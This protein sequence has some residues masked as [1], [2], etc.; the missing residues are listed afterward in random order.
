VE[1][2]FGK[3]KHG[4]FLALVL[5]SL[6]ISS[7]ELCY[8]TNLFEDE[9]IEKARVLSTSPTSRSYAGVFPY[10]KNARGTFFLLSRELWGGDKGTCCDFGG[11]VDLDPKT[12]TYFH[13]GSGALNELKEESCLVYDLGNKRGFQLLRD[14]ALIYHTPTAMMA[15][16]ELPYHPSATFNAARSNLIQKKAKH[17]FL[18]KD[19]FIWVEGGSLLAAVE[20]FPLTRGHKDVP[21]QVLNDNNQILNET[22]KLRSS[23]TTSLRKSKNLLR[24]IVEAPLIITPAQPV[25][26]KP[27]E[28]KPVVQPQPKPVQ[29]VQKPVEQP[30]SVQAQPKPVQPVQKPVEQPKPVQA[31]PKPVQPVQKPVEQPKPVQAQPKPVVQ[32]QPKP[33]QPVVQKPVEPK[34]VVQPRPKPV[35]PVVQKPV[36]PKPVIQPQPKP[37]IQLQPKPVVKP[38]PKPV[39]QPQSKPMVQPQPKP[40]VKPQPKPAIQPQPKPMI[41]LQPKP[42][43][44]PQPKPVV[45]PQA[46]PVVKPQPKPVV[47]PQAKQV[48]QPKTRLITAY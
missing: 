8:G 3:V 19:R 20:G 29:P 47:Q 43:V 30:K 39:I 38:Q 26:Q 45:Q 46:K 13:F 28:P 31:Q 11:A 7:L 27:V 22:I 2:V 12:K 9:I 36:E 40:V 1:V 6:L 25:I 44:K 18:E 24:R 42:V 35:Q 15:Y 37:M 33:V 5:C 21:V 34:P 14:N 4:L 32:P 23:F 17:S 41:Q 10:T 48:I 16:L